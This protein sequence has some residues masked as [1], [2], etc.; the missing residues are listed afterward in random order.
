MLK[1]IKGEGFIQGKPPI[2]LAS[3]AHDSTGKHK[4]SFHA[5]RDLAAAAKDSTISSLN[6]EGFIISHSQKPGDHSSGLLDFVAAVSSTI[7]GPFDAALLSLWQDCYRS[8]SFQC[9]VHLWCTASAERGYPRR[10][11]FW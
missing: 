9:Y 11:L 8:S 2:S 6:R 1:G 5:G 10:C 4:M 3:E 7:H